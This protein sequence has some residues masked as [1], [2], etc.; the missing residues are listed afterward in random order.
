MLPESL[1]G[2]AHR[3]GLICREWEL[4]ITGRCL[5]EDLGRDAGT[6][7][8]DVAGHDIVKAF[9]SDRFDHVEGTR[10]VSRLSTG[11][12]VWVVAR[13]HDHRGGT[14][15]DEKNHVVWLVAYRRHRS[16]EDDDF[17]PYARELDAEGRLHPTRD[18]YRRLLE[19]R[20]YRFAAAV[21]IEA[22]LVLKA[23]REDGVETRIMFGGLYGACVAVEVADEIGATTVAFRVGTL[24]WD[25]VPIIL[26][27]LHTTPDW[28]LADTMP[29]RDLDPDEV[30]FTYVYEQE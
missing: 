21:R 25:H 14:W 6:P 7:F 8:G 23:A 13:G 4:R 18:D 29:S 2:E 24:P 3:G 10:D 20:D 26:Q 17:F 27:A 5:T 28:E 16:G 9:V 11:R 19:D 30:A 12:T 1:I 15:F 22:P